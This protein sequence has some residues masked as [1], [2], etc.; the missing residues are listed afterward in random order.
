[1]PRMQSEATDSHVKEIQVHKEDS[2][3]LHVKMDNV[4]HLL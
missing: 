1:M 2:S 4:D 3:K